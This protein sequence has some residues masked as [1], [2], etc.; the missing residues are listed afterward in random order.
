MKYNQ[1]NIFFKILNKEI[2]CNK[3]LETKHALAFYDISPKAKT[4]VLVI[5]KGSYIDIYDFNKNANSEEI[6]LFW[7]AANLVVEK[8]GLKS[9]G[10]QIKSN[11]GD[12]GGQEVFHFHIHIL[13]DLA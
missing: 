8:L 12:G 3:V 1:N 9:L 11:I 10:Y 13:S 5:P 7:Q 6:L 4:H 2:P